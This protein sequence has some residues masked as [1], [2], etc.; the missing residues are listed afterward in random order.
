MKKS[1]ELIEC[2]YCSGL[3]PADSVF[4][5]RCGERLA[6][7]K[8]VVSGPKM[9][10]VPEPKQLPSG[11]WRIYLRKEQKSITADNYAE[12]KATA[13]AY[14][15]GALELPDEVQKLPALTLEKACE[16]YIAERSDSC[17]PSTIGGYKCIVRTRF[18]DYIKTD[19]REINYQEM[20]NSEASICGAKTLKNS[21]LFVVSVLK[22]NRAYFSEIGTELP[23]V[24]L[25]AVV[26]P[27]T[28]WLDYSQIQTFLKAVKG[29]DCEIGA[30]LALHG[31]RR[32]EL[33]AV[34]PE[35]IKGNNII[36]KGAVVKGADNKFIAKETN[37]N[38]SSARTVPIMIPRLQELLANSNCLPGQPYVTIYPDKL[39]VKINEVC[40][41]SG[42]PLV[43]VHGLRRSFCSL[44][45]HLKLSELETMQLGG[46][47]D[48]N[49]MRDIYTKL[50]AA[51]QL[52][53]VQKLKD[54]YKENQ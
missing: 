15:A 2:R 3:T 50:A 54:F 27:D 25:P 34:T 24:K 44:C 51:D 26:K 1:V 48:F 36:V 41:S 33:L 19:I 35:K 31:L 29:K 28:A 17:S 42:L 22:K 53:A 16:N 45:Y 8:R 12:C 47:S 9:P 14:R 20:V 5:C 40:E 4:C 21:W 43:G 18:K 46:W 11:S 49:T 37:K 30:L 13:E 23:E 38:E 39:F 7:A 10:K 32:S 52:A 6:K